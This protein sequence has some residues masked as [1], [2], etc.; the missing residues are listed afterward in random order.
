MVH[1][2]NGMLFS[3]KRQEMLSCAI[4]QMNLKNVVLNLVSWTQKGKYMVLFA[5][6]L[7]EYLDTERTEIIRSRV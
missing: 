5:S 4:T 7:D 6:R 2:Y 1:P 3:N